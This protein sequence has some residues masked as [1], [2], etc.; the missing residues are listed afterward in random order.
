MIDE[1]ATMPEEK[2]S[3]RASTRAAGKPSTGCCCGFEHPEVPE[4]VW[5]GFEEAEGGKGIET[6]DERFEHPPTL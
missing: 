3:W 2:R 5:E 6:R 1:P 4:D